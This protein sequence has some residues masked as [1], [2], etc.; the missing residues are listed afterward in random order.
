MRVEVRQKE[1]LVCTHMELG[2]HNSCQAWRALRIVLP[3]DVSANLHEC[4][5]GP[6]PLGR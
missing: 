4:T 6:S 2:G 1:I 5:K 3:E